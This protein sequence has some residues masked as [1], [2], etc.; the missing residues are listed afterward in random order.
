MNYLK[1][2]R[3]EHWIKNVLLFFPITFNFQL[4]E[5]A[6][7]YKVI[8]GFLIFSIVASMI[9][10]FNDIKDYENDCKHPKKKVRPLASGKISK[11]QA[12]NTE[13]VLC[14][15]LIFLSVWFKPPIMFYFYIMLYIIINLLYSMGAKNVPLVDV[16]ILASGYLIR[17]FAG[18]VLADVKV[19]DWMFL[20]V[21][22][23]AFF[24][25]F[26][27]RRNELV[28]YGQ[29]GRKILDK[30]TIGF[31][32][33]SLQL[34]STLTI[35]CYSLCCADQNTV[36]AQQG[37]SLLWSVPI[38]ILV[39]LRYNMILEDESSDGDPVTVVKNDKIL[40]GLIGIYVVFV[41]GLIY[42]I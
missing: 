31:L 3:V 18:G 2:M 37:I 6:L 28:Q 12:I 22:S 10:I 20:T 39:M 24:L 40:I 29:E 23:T 13:I 15:I 35:V 21:L 16:T 30:Y 5:L 7:T 38:V 1:E 9:Y 27:K 34:F 33:K 41:I 4:R 26:G 14:I 17:L 42:V 36:V 8:I 19:S 32:D 25:G 11:R